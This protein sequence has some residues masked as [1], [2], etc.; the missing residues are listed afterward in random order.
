MLV[1]SRSLKLWLL[2]LIAREGEAERA[3]GC[4]Q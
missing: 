4:L 3:R 2:E 1:P